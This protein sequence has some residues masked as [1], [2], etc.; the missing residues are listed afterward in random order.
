MLDRRAD[1]LDGDRRFPGDPAGGAF[2]AR[3]AHHG[4]PFVDHVRADPAPGADHQF[5]APW[6]RRVRRGT[7]PRGAPLHSADPARYPGSAWTG[8]LRGEHEAKHR[9]AVL[10]DFG[11][12]VRGGRHC[13]K[14]PEQGRWRR[15]YEAAWRYPERARDLEVPYDQTEGAYPLGRWLSD[16]RRTYR[17]GP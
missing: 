9:A 13:A 16:W 10:A 3:E 17:A 8:W 4:N 11:R 1:G 2:P 5:T 15:G 12:R 7:G 14:S 6:R